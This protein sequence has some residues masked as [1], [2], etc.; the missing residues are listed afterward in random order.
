[1]LHKSDQFIVASKFAEILVFRP[2]MIFRFSSS[3]ILSFG[4]AKQQIVPGLANYF[5]GDF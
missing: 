3:R 2:E 4:D 1:M 5:Y